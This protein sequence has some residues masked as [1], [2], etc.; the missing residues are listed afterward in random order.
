MKNY[1]TE[2]EVKEKAREVY[3]KMC[4]NLIIDGEQYSGNIHQRAI[5]CALVLVNEQIN[6]C[7]DGFSY[8]DYRRNFWEDVKNEL[9]A[10]IKTIKK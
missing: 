3:D 9:E 4:Y 2:K 6:E 5:K 7:L 8:T 10:Y 1:Y